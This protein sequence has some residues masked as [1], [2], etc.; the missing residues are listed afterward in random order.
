MSHQEWKI[1]HSPADLPRRRGIGWKRTVLPDNSGITYENGNTGQRFLYVGSG[2]GGMARELVQGEHPRQSQAESQRS[3]RPGTSRILYSSLDNSGTKRSSLQRAGAIVPADRRGK[4]P[5]QNRDEI[6]LRAQELHQERVIAATHTV[7]RMVPRQLAPVVQERAAARQQALDNH[8]TAL[9]I[10]GDRI[11][12]LLGLVERGSLG[13]EREVTS[14]TR[15]ENEY[16]SAMSAT[17]SR[18]R[19][20]VNPGAVVRSGEVTHNVRI[21]Q[22]S[23]ESYGGFAAAQNGYSEHSADTRTGFASGDG[24]IAMGS[25][26]TTGAQ[27]IEEHFHDS[28]IYISGGDQLD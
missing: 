24:A 8:R 22:E 20:G 7:E 19:Y 13:S 16:G 3:G 21:H 4:S 14:A 28:G 11:S 5:G 15:I 23:A 25:V 6:A 18:V 17:R 10:V 9:Q 26:V 12:R 27:T 1:V 2:I